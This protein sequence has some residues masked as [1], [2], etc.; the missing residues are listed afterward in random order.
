M[1]AKIC[2]QCTNK[3]LRAGCLV[4]FQKGKSM[5]DCRNF[6]PKV[7]TPMFLKFLRMGRLKPESIEEAKTLAASAA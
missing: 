6:Y 1:D 5:K 7:G 2:A 3:N 4:C